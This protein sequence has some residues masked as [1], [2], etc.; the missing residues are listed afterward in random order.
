MWTHGPRDRRPPRHVG[1]DRIVDGADHGR[2]RAR[3]ARRRGRHPDPERLRRD[4]HVVTRSARL[5]R[6]GRDRDPQR[7][8]P[9]AVRHQALHDTLTGLPNRALIHDRVEHMLARARRHDSPVCRRCSST[10]TG[11]RRQRLARPRGRRPAPATRRAPGSRRSCAT[12][13]PSARLGGDE[14][15]VLVEGARSTP[16]PEL[17]AERLL[18]VLR[19]PFEIGDRA[20]SLAVTASIGI[21][22]G[23]RI[24]PSELLRD[25]DIALYNAKAAGKDRYSVFLPE[26]HTVLQDRLTMETDLRRRVER[27]EFFLV[28]QPIVDLARAR[29]HRRRSTLPMAPPDTRRRWSPTTFIPILERLRAHRRCRSLGARRSLPPGRAW[30]AAGHAIDISVNV[31]VRQLDRDAFVGDVGETSPAAGLDPRSLVSRSPK[32]RSCATPRAPPTQLRAQGPAA[33]ASRS[34]TSAP[35]TRRSRTSGSSPSTRS[36]ST[37]L[38]RRDRRIS[39]GRRAHPHARAAG[40][41]AGLETLAEGIEDDEQFAGS[42]RRSATAAKAFSSR[43]RSTLPGSRSSSPGTCSPTAPRRHRAGLTRAVTATGCADTEAVGGDQLRARPSRRTRRARVMVNPAVVSSC[44]IGRSRWHPPKSRCSSGSSRCCHFCTFSSGASPCST[45]CSV[46]PGFSTRRTSRSAAVD[47]GNRAQR[48]RRQ[49]GVVGV[50]GERQRRAVE[51]GALD[52]DRRGAESL[53]ASFQPRSAGSTA[54]TWVTAGG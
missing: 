18:D 35:A 21:A 54:A 31:S 6:P 37:G 28:Y 45:K 1:L 27:D 43:A 24:S 3:R 36:R 41:D 8:T 33:C 14:F 52:R 2:R 4:P 10:S 25:A 47:V 44:T 11:S 32:P 26:M 16:A 39:R 42:R 29:N 40:Q 12:A 38:H 48:P 51:A 17:V 30:H 9:R 49:R 5:R 53:S 34:T 50:V 22:V 46:P 20:T 13:T 7:V 19:E 23:D 15:V